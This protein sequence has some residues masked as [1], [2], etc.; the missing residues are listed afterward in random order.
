MTVIP[1]D[2]SIRKVLVLGSGAIKIAEAGE[3]DYSGSQA[4]KALRE[5]GI[6]AVLVNPNVATIQTDTS[7]TDKVYLLPVTPKYV[8]RVI[9]AERPD[10]VLLGFGGQ[11][12]LNCG[13]MLKKMGVFE[14]YGVKVLGTSVEAI[15][16]ASDRAMFK[17][18]M[19]DAGINVL[20]SREAYTLE[21][22]FRVAEQIGYPVIVRTAFT[23]GGRGGGVA[24]NPEELEVIVRRGLAHSIVSQVLIE[25]YI[26]HWK[27]VEF[28]VMRD[29]AGNSVTVCDME[30]ILSMRVHTGDNTVVAPSQ[31]LT[32]DE[33]HM[34]REVS[35]RAAA[36]VGVIGECNVQFA[37][38]P[39]SKTYYVI[40]M[41]PR[42]SRSSALASKATGYPIAYVAA[43]LALG[44]SLNELKNS[45]TGITTAAF[46]PSLDYVVVKMPRFEFSKYPS[47]KRQLGT[48]M[49][50]I[51][52]VM[53]IGRTFEEALQKAVRMLDSGREGGCDYKP[54]GSKEKVLEAVSNPT[55]EFFYNLAEAC[56]MGVD[57]EEL[58]RR[59]WVDRWFI[60]RVRSIVEFD[61]KLMR[62]A[63]ARVEPSRE[64]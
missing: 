50:S 13:F 9:E 29:S 49:K 10:G 48:Q 39:Q 62:L 4:I 5:E 61:K 44:Y 58:Y 18:T 19:M 32:N 28:E 47:V 7:L 38:D 20:E 63:E 6:E 59:S 60:E 35:M 31:T 46:E 51:G 56:A 2:R 57:T 16:R 21:Q 64:V 30:N 12:A 27:Q 17:K 23:L 22:A 3:F 1:L 15:E 37:L 14:K 34:L 52:E 40:E 33:Y 43:K 41:N 55:D 54:L 8:E 42:L 24:R 45:V 53:G 25:R 36:A 26:G 11:T